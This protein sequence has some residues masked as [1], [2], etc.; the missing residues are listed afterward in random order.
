MNHF[1][2]AF[3]LLPYSAGIK[4]QLV[5]SA[6][7]ILIGIAVEILSGCGNVIGGFYIALMG[8]MPAQ[9][10]V[11][12]TV[13]AAV[14]SSPL[15]RSIAVEFYALINFVF[16]LVCFSVVVAV[17]LIYG[18]LHQERMDVSMS[19][20][21]LVAVVVLIAELSMPLMYKHYWAGF[22]LMMVCVMALFSTLIQYIYGN[23]SFHLPFPVYLIAGYLL[24]VL[25]L[26]FGIGINRLCY[27][28]ELDPMCYKNMVKKLDGGF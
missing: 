22:V 2:K 17:H 20:V 15:Y 21:L 26:F 3:K 4:K 23:E 10:L 9:A 13:P 5:I 12:V 25:G 19:L 24:V 1:K 7:L 27:R 14:K 11:L 18:L 16:E 8:A 28:H 6:I